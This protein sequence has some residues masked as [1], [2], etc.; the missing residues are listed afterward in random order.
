MSEGVF[1]II[2]TITWV[3]LAIL[4]GIQIVKLFKHTQDISASHG[5]LDQLYYNLKGKP[6][7]EFKIA[8]L[9]EVVPDSWEE[10][11]ALKFPGMQQYCNCN[12]KYKSSCNPEK[13]A[14]CKL[15]PAQPA[16]LMNNWRGKKIIYRRYKKKEIKYIREHKN[17]EVKC[18]NGFKQ[19]TPI[20]C[21][22]DFVA[23]PITHFWIN[24][25]KKQWVQ[26]NDFIHKYDLGE[27]DLIMERRNDSN[28]IVNGFDLELNGM[29]CYN[30][31]TFHK[32]VTKHG[33]ALAYKMD[34]TGC[35]KPL[36]DNIEDY[37]SVDRLSLLDFLGDNDMQ[38]YVDNIPNSELSH[39]LEEKVHLA[40]RFKL[41]LGL[42]E[43]CQDFDIEKI[44]L[45]NIGIT[46][47]FTVM[48]V[49]VLLCVVV[50]LYL[51]LISKSGFGNRVLWLGVI[52]GSFNIGSWLMNKVTHEVTEGFIDK[53]NTTFKNNHCLGDSKLG[54]AF[55][56]LVNMVHNLLHDEQEITKILFIASGVLIVFGGITKLLT[57]G[58][59]QVLSG[60]DQKMAE[61][62]QDRKNK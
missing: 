45:F 41:F 48:K 37:R 53:V 11:T 43:N 13:D 39:L 24:K 54:K 8:D 36:A 4:M 20:H 16:G 59:N 6:I 22:K 19:C 57:K 26:E 32:L 38:E 55:F 46:T 29:P 7:K 34:G 47:L 2:R 44:H 12:G 33:S 40:A 23:C 15:Y 27:D 61:G 49:F 10:V 9:Q 50:F 3:A 18:E 28:R 52:N 31:S 5:I 21:V 62:I 25:G 60:T 35:Q 58:S 30:P 51:G 17:G 56:Q 42:H 14:D 1:R